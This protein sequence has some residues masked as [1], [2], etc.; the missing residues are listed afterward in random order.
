MRSRRFVSRFAQNEDGGPLV[1][2]A[3]ILPIMITVL[4]GGIDF[5]NAFYQW[6][7]AAKAV[8]IGAR[9][10]AVSDPVASG[11][12]AIPASV[13]S[14]TEVTGDPM[15]DFDVACDGGVSN[16]ACVAGTCAG[17]GSYSA[18]AMGLIVYG[19]GGY[20]VCQQP[21]SQY[22]AGM[23]NIFERISP[24]NVTI[25]YAQTGLGYAG[26][27]LGP[28][29]TITVSL[30]EASSPSKLPFKFFFLPFADIAI[31]SVATTVTGEA[32]SASASN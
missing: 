2:V 27:T 9:I 19:R 32:L 20:G 29:P 24:A 3:V 18:R 6:N 5:L 22:F 15:P 11:L 23:C 8:E 17:M 14:S 12:N 16:C 1:E 26:R 10:A 31:P 7:A 28:V 13:L 21:K 25:T 4:F 30:N